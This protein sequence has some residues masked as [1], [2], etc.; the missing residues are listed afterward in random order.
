MV[1]VEAGCVP[2]VFG[3]QRDPGAV[4]ARRETEP[5]EDDDPVNVTDEELR[6]RLRLGEDSAWEFKQIEFS[7]DRPTS[8]RC[9]DLADEMAAFANATGGVP[10]CGVSDGRIQGMSTEQMAALDRLLVEVSTDAVEPPLRINVHRR[11]L[12]G[13]ALVLVNVSRGSA[14]HERAG[15]AYIQRAGRAYIRVG[16]TKRRL[17]GDERLRLAQRR[18]QSRYLWFDQQIVRRTGFRTLNERLWEPLLSMAGAADPRRALRNLR[19]LASDEA[20]VDRATVAG[21]LLCTDSPQEW[22]PQATIMAT[23]YRGKDRASGQLDAQ[24]IVGPLPIQ[25]ADAVK[26]VIRNMRGLRRARCL[27]GKMHRSTARRPCSRP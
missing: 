8:P 10:L 19:L 24:E 17:G 18:A 13:R 22:L 15:R 4:R 9:E 25:I 6:Q 16:G 3:G 27:R 11:E 1:Y 20:E 7:G 12:D 5:D 23:H 21:V 14:V 2:Y 26:F